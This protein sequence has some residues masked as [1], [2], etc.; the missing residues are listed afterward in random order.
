MISVDDGRGSS[1]LRLCDPEEESYFKGK[2]DDLNN[3]KMLKPVAPA[4]LFIACW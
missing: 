1:L 4:A 3:A 2:Q